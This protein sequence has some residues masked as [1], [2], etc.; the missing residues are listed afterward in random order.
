MDDAISV[1]RFVYH[2]PKVIKQ[3]LFIQLIDEDRAVSPY[4]DQSDRAWEWLREQIFRYS[5]VQDRDTIL[6]N[7][8]FQHEEVAVEDIFDAPESSV[9]DY[10]CPYGTP[11]P[12]SQTLGKYYEA[13]MVE[14][15]T[16]P[17]ESAKAH[18]VDMLSNKK[19]T[20]QDNYREDLECDLPDGRQPKLAV[21][22]AFRS[23]YLDSSA[24]SPSQTSADSPSQT[25]ADPPSQ[26]SADPTLQNSFTIMYYWY[27]DAMLIDE[28]IHLLIHLDSCRVRKLLQDVIVQACVDDPNLL[29]IM[30][31]KCKDF[32]AIYSSKLLDLLPLDGSVESLGVVKLNGNINPKLFAEILYEW[33]SDYEKLK[34]LPDLLNKDA[35]NKKMSTNKRTDYI[36][37]DKKLPVI[38]IPKDKKQAEKQ[39][40]NFINAFLPDKKVTIIKLNCKIKFLWAIYIEIHDDE[41]CILHRM[42]DIFRVW[43][44]NT[45]RKPSPYT[46]KTNKDKYN[47]SLEYR[48]IQHI[49][50]EVENR[51]IDKTLNS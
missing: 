28:I 32:D 4:Y 11:L 47:D 21:L 12:S 49:F 5:N 24:D 13:F 31:M 30:R 41:H 27:I 46:I 15:D 51:I 6:T 33:I 19:I 45:L 25:S 7:L 17:M 29:K 2:L 39:R 18:Y 50:K 37:Y 8:G 3:R 26:T 44:D 20:V 16:D 36:Q 22:N 35:K 23:W 1:F 43:K 10:K 48:L 40:E 14:M 9:Y 42:C 38:T 34:S